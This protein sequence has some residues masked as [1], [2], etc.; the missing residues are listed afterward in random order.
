MKRKQPAQL[1]RQRK[2]EDE[3]IARTK[4]YQTVCNSLKQT[5]EDWRCIVHSSLPHR[6]GMRASFRIPENFVPFSAGPHKDLIQ[7][8]VSEGWLEET[9][10]KVGTTWQLSLEVLESHWPH[11]KIISVKPLPEKPK[12]LPPIPPLV[13]PDIFD[14]EPILPK[15]TL[16]LT[17][18]G[19][20]LAATNPK[21]FSASAVA[22]EHCATLMAELDSIE[23]QVL[24]NLKVAVTEE[25][26]DEEEQ[27][28][29]KA[30]VEEAEEEESSDEGLD[31]ANIL[32]ET[33]ETYADWR[34]NK[35]R[36]E[37]KRRGLSPRGKNVELAARLR[38][39]DLQNVP[40]KKRYR[41]RKQDHAD[42]EAEEVPDEEISESE[43]EEKEF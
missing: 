39:N 43:E 28:K 29:K 14:D 10:S 5:L 30:R 32:P 3:A 24:S 27:P 7:A 11:G 35:L 36:A 19:K 20:R 21:P 33:Q 26:S 15:P 42:L 13:D 2:E 34:Q 9:E 22:S 16:K 1:R 37:C 38:E 41:I 23:K 4:N 25:E 40:V 31:K 8:G 12:D 18:A 17:D 6:W